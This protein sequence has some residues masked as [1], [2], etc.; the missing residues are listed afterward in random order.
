MPGK[1][2]IQVSQSQKPSRAKTQKTKSTKQRRT[3]RRTKKIAFATTYAPR[4][5]YFRIKRN[6]NNSQEIVV[7]G[8]DLI[9]PTP[10][11]LP[12][13]AKAAQIFLLV[14]ANPLYWVGTRISGIAAVY[15]QFRPLGF[16]VE[17]IPQVPVTC[18]GQVIVGTL[19]NNGSP[20]QTLQQ[21][22]MS[23]NGG[24]MRACY[25]KFHSHVICSK[26]TLP[27][28]FYNV[29]DDLAL[30]TS[31]PFYW[32]AHY[33][34]AWHSNTT[35][36]TS[37]PGWIYVKWKYA[38]SVG[39]GNRGT[40][41]VVYNQL[42][43]QSV[44]RINSRYNLGLSPGW[45]VTFSYLKRIGL[46]ILRKVC[47]V[48][49]DEV[50]ALAAASGINDVGDATPIKLF[51]G[52]AFTVSPA[53][54]SK[55][56]GTDV[57][58]RASDGITYQVSDDTRIVCYMEGEE[59]TGEIFDKYTFSLAKIESGPEFSGVIIYKHQMS[60]SM[61]AV[62]IRDTL[63]KLVATVVVNFYPDSTLIQD[64][65]LS[66]TAAG[67]YQISAY[68]EAMNNETEEV[69]TFRVN[70]S[71]TSPE[72]LNSF[73]VAYPE[74]IEN[75]RLIAWYSTLPTYETA[76]LHYLPHDPGETILNFHPASLL[77]HANLMA[78]F[79]RMQ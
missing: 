44:A 51:T 8:E 35:P 58:L 71:L 31:N 37:Q 49:V 36:T 22:L 3:Q 68:Y 66:K 20:T 19:W 59:V 1:T 21:T 12:T 15:Q 27:L 48:L 61:L 64:L 53:E 40:E 57:T 55:A 65:V 10:N 9:I 63:G 23:S 29:H 6:R 46:K 54:F 11:T 33:S 26:R 60:D 2:V 77:A 70:Y 13:E 32:M 38:F 62:D 24:N 73:I 25:E 42:D 45:G 56:L 30:N 69:S 74:I 28:N 50:N 72:G 78:K 7:E 67:S 14:P 76:I 43:D 17:Y 18:P 47:A 4:K 41:V 5:P 39:L 79:A 34:G 52:S 16:D 75:S